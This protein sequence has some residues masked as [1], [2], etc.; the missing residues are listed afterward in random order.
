MILRD[1]AR[2]GVSR[3]LKPGA[4]DI[5]SLLEYKSIVALAK[6]TVFPDIEGV[7]PRPAGQQP[8]KLPPARSNP[9]PLTGYSET[10]QLTANECVAPGNRVN[11]RYQVACSIGFQNIAT[12]KV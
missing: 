7:I 6:T 11:C 8:M 2:R 4:K 12:A 10:G 5:R 1:R 9:F 3:D